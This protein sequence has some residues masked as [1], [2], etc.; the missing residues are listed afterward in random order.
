MFDINAI[1]NNAITQAVNEATQ[2]L[3][4]HIVGLQQRIAALENNPAIGTDT[5]LAARIEA[6]E[7][8]T[9]VLDQHG[10]ILEYLDNQEWFWDKLVNKTKEIA[11]AAAEA[12]VAE[13]CND[14]DHDD[15]D[16]ISGAVDRI[17]LDEIVCKDDLKDA[18]KETLDDASF[19]IRVSF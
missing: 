2:G 18:V 15:Y 11:D 10:G 14:Y 6:L 7:K 12:A 3:V 13:H 9:A 8:H 17:D 1:I 19:D 4:E 5:T 16:R